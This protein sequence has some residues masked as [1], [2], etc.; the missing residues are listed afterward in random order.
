MALI[1]KIVPQIEWDAAEKTGVFTGSPVDVKDGFIHF[2]TADQVTETA[3]KH[4]KGL[5]NLLLII[6][7]E[8]LLDS[9]A[10]KYEISRGGDLFPHLYGALALDSIVGVAKFEANE[11]GLFSFSEVMS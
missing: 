7:E 2:S 6:V 11:Q 4:F 8:D 3:N 5:S 9:D 10:L 1:Y